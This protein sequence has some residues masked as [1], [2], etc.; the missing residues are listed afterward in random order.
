MRIIDR[1]K[2]L[3]WKDKGGTYEAAVLDDL[4][5]LNQE[6]TRAR[7]TVLIRERGHPTHFSHLPP[8]KAVKRIGD[9]RM[10]GNFS[11]IWVNWKGKSI[12][13]EKLLQIGW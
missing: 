4:K 12:Q 10:M 7:C 5:Y 9:C 2:D 13:L 11:P 6:Q 8:G 3:N 1:L